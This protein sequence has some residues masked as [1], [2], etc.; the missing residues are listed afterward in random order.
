MLL[1]LELGYVVF[2]DYF[3]NEEKVVDVILVVRRLGEVIDTV[4][5]GLFRA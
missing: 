4:T 3:S 5:V 1:A 2:V